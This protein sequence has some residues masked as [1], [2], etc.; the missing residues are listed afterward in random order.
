MS[1][2]GKGA[3]V[4]NAGRGGDASRN[5][6]PALGCPLA[7]GDVV[8]RRWEAADAAALIEAGAD[9]SIRAWMPKMPRPYGPTEAASFLRSTAAWWEEGSRCELAVSVETEVAGL[10]GFTIVDALPREGH[11]GY[12]VLTR[13]RGRGI[14]ATALR[15]MTSWAL[16]Q[17]LVDRLVCRVAVANEASRVTAERAGYVQEGREPVDDE[18]RGRQELVVMVARGEAGQ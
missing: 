7:D 17:G 12:W 15:L 10:C 3:V 14:A 4:P 18:V 9:R 2:D 16:A 13:H 8:V 5:G 11:V 1:S 6:F